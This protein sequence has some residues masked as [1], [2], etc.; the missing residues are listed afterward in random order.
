MFHWRTRSCV[1][2]S[3]VSGRLEA[4]A[5]ALRDNLFLPERLLFCSSRQI[6]PEVCFGVIL[7]DTFS[8][9]VHRPQLVLGSG[10]TLRCSL[11]QPLGRQCIVLRNPHAEKIG[12]TEPALRCGVSIFSSLAVPPHRLNRVF[13]N[14][15]SIPI[16]L[17]ET[18]LRRRIRAAFVGPGVP[19]NRF[20]F[21][22]CYSSSGIV[23]PSHKEFRIGISLIGRLTKPAHRFRVVSRDA[24]AV[25]IRNAEVKPRKCISMA[26]GL[27]VPICCPL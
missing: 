8:C 3:T 25:V 12:R 7:R 21:V 15:I 20:C 27:A 5:F 24:Q 1:C 23:G 26:G 19:K 16:N 4:A 22:L 9:L 2:T 10:S 14:A 11:S 18:I 6:E 17:A 13:G